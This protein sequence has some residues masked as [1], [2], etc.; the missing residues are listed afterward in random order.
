MF[1]KKNARGYFGCEDTIACPMVTLVIVYSPMGTQLRET[2]PQKRVSHEL[3]KG[4]VELFLG[5]FN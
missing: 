2:N 3:S 5:F 1:T 4:G